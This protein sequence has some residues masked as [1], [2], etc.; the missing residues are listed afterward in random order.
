ML[1]G[2]SLSARRSHVN[3]LSLAQKLGARESNDSI[4]QGPIAL[5]PLLCI[6]GCVEADSLREVSLAVP[7]ALSQNIPSM[8]Y[9]LPM[10][11][12]AASPTPHPP[13]DLLV[14]SRE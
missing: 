1:R 6:M 9:Y 13:N 10:A 11:L 5:K 7:A 12:N 2:S 8:C 3:V 4:A 14:L